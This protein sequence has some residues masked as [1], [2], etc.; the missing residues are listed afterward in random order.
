MATILTEKMRAVLRISSTDDD[1]T[2][3]INDTIEAAKADLALSGV[4]KLDEKDPAIVRAITLYC[5]ANYG[6]NTDS[7]KYNASYQMQK[8]SLCCAS[9]YTQPAESEGG[10]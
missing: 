8:H 5:K 1:V 10:V 3:E 4:K 6:Y 7:E 2:T 9:E